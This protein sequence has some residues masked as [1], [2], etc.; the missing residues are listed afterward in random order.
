VPTQAMARSAITNGSR[1]LQD[2]DGRSLWARRLRDLIKGHTA[3]LG[4][5]DAVSQAEQ[6]LIRRA[7]MMCLQ[8]ELL[9]QRWA[10]ADDGAAT[11]KE[12]ETYQR[13]TSSLRRVLDSL[14]LARRPRDVS[15]IDKLI[16][17]AL[18]PE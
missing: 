17:A 8:L 6:V 4:G 1:L 13:V 14:G 7:S 3:D 12:I 11:S 5:A 9:E 18:A 2:L 16:D 15:P 10:L